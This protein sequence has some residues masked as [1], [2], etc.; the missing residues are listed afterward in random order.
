MSE[1][2][3]YTFTLTNEEH[4]FLC[5]AIDH[6]IDAYKKKPTSMLARQLVST[7]FGAPT[8]QSPGEFLDW[9]NSLYKK[10]KH[11]GA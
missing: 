8:K 6:A 7:R 4:G 2:R 9:A 5:F 3:K 1:A 10:V 11:T